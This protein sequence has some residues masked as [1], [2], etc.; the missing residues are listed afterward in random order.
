[1]EEKVAAG[2]PV[3]LA[4]VGCGRWGPNHIRAFQQ[5]DGATVTACCDT[6][7]GAV[8]RA[9][10][11]FNIN[12]YDSFSKLLAREDIDAVVVATPVTTHREVVKE[13]FAHGLDVLCE[14]PLDVDVTYAEEIVRGAFEHGRILMVGHVFLYN[15]GILAL[16]ALL[17]SGELGAVRYAYSRRTNLGP[18][19]YDVGAL[20]DLATHDISIMNFLMEEWTPKVAGCF[21]GCLEGDERDMEDVAFATLRYKWS[22]FAHLHVSWVDPVKVRQVVV[23]GAK[24]MAIWDDLRPEGP[25]AVYDRALEV[26]EEKFRL[27]SLELFKMREKHGGVLLPAVKQGEPL[28]N[29]ALAFVEA[30]QTRREPL[31]AGWTGVEIARTLKAMRSPA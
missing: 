14:K 12:A 21:R 6:D 15:D 3:K 30:V 18:V 2:P 25:I 28:K 16:K 27:G 31:S 24:K 8:T 22:K 29:Q 11:A 10:H 7:T 5:L 1:M 23:V 17:D 4:V 13:A 26:S 20:A 9:A 19:R